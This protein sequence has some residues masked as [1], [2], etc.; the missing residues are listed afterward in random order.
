MIK[1]PCLA[2]AY[3]QRNNAPGEEEVHRTGSSKHREFKAQ[4]VQRQG[5]Q[6]QGVQRQGVKEQAGTLF[7]TRLEPIKAMGSRIHKSH[8]LKNPVELEKE[9]QNHH[10]V[11]MSHTI[12]ILMLLGVCLIRSSF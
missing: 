2:T 8:G 6:R 12:F 11:R 3:T 7:D 9:A 5:V 10:W 1:N 4:G